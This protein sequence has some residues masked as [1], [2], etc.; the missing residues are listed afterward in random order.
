MEADLARAEVIEA[1]QHATRGAAMGT[2]AGV[3]GFFAALFAC[4]TLMF[5]LDTF[6]PLWLAALITTAVVAALAA[7]L[8]AMARQE[9]KRF[10][11]V[12]R[13]FMK[14]MKEDIQWAK[15]QTR[16]S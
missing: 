6:M 4:L 1:R 11:P 2:G 13:R 5:V 9:F 12:P 10:S 8:G 14:S 16:S 7:L 15:A 3:M